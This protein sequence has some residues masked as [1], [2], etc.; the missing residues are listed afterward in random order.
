[1]KSY[2]LRLLGLTGCAALALGACGK[3]ATNNTDTAPAPAPV[4]AAKASIT[5]KP[6]GTL[7]DGTSV[8]LY[9]LKNAAGAEVDITNFGGIVTS[10]KVP[11]RDG[12]LAD[13]VLGYDTLE[14]YAKNPSHFGSTIGR[15]ANRIAK[16]QFK[17]DG[18]TYKLA[19]NNG[20][21]TLHG[22]LK[23]FDK[24]VWQADAFEKPDSVGVVLTYTSPD[25]EE[26]YPGTLATR[27]TFTFTNANELAVDYSAT[28]DKPTVLN[29]TNH[30]YFNLAGE[31]SGD[32]LGHVLTLNSDRYTPANATLIPTG[33]LASVTGTPFD[34]RTA[35]A[36]G[37][38]I[39]ADDPQLKLGN[40]YD[41]NFVINRAGNELALAARVEEPKS[42]RVLE[43]RTTEP[44]VQLY[45]ANHLDGSDA[46]K[47]G[48]AYAKNSAFCLE[49][50]HY[51]DSPNQSSFPSTTLRP[52]ETFQSRTVY[53]FSVSDH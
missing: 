52:G 46:G 50:Q 23:G 53:R 33:E 13:V 37:A 28:T 15:Y 8:E 12:K 29:F 40:G 48:H 17:L 41:H 36:L 24:M 16:A 27:V 26:G 1:M 4:A 43:V 14:G 25:G 44:G 38:R 32:V 2:R 6:F 39:D 22:G 19:A 47:S 31:G 42:G 18:K 10:I 9:T 11:D 3:P 51:P 5:H 30:S 7:A 45:T 34:F 35:T 21:N 20:V 49:T